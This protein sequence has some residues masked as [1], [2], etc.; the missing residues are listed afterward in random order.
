M[1]NIVC[2]LFAWLFVLEREK[3]C[4]YEVSE[5]CPIASDGGPPLRFAR[6][7]LLG[8]RS[9]FSMNEH[10][11]ATYE[12]SRVGSGGPIRFSLKLHDVSMYPVS[13]T[14]LMIMLQLPFAF[15]FAHSVRQLLQHGNTSE[16]H[17]C[18]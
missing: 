1:L 7:V 13:K 2:R 9:C 3:P 14:A 5:I 11:F 18:R 6:E 4:S 17:A 10:R 12:R 16:Q 15:H 8:V